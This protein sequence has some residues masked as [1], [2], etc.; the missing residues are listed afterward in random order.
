MASLLARAAVCQHRRIATAHRLREADQLPQ[1]PRRRHNPSP[2]RSTRQ[3]SSGT[4][5]HHGH[6][7]PV[8]RFLRAGRRVETAAEATSSHRRPPVVVFSGAYRREGSAGSVARRR[9]GTRNPQRHTQ[10]SRHRSHLRKARHVAARA[11][12]ERRLTPLAPKRSGS[13]HPPNRASRPTRRNAPTEDEQHTRP[14][15]PRI[16][17]RVSRG[18][19]GS[20]VLDVAGRRRS[21]AMLAGY[22]C[23]RPPR[24]RGLRYPADPPSVEK[25]VAV[26][27]SAHD[28]VDGRRARGLIIVLWRAGLR[29]SEALALAESDLDA[30]RGPILVRRRKGARRREVGMDR[31]GWERLQPWLELRATL[32]AGALFWVIHGPSAGR[33]WAP[34][35]ARAR[36][37]RVAVCAGVRRRFAPHQ[38]HHAHAVE[39][40][41]E[42]VPLVVIQRQ[43]AAGPCQSWDHLGLPAG[44]R[45]RRDHRHRPRTLG[46][47]DFG[48]RWSALHAITLG[49]RLHAES[50][51][52]AW[53]PPG[54]RAGGR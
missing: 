14:R 19:M 33:P 39:T 37:R 6:G 9:A 52:C 53:V 30:Q 22:H 41:R 7:G 26:M 11:A 27:R 54:R 45:Q 31:W 35:A 34:A 44:H 47:H 1:R 2:Q 20:A 5:G 25:I 16:R 38:L 12:T 17:S 28:S 24:N 18:V 21:P 40:A 10:P 42:G 3:R 4:S 36:L 50:S 29:I 8:R 23:G 46:T 49:P 15:P 13:K 43:L 51:R 32:P 48:K